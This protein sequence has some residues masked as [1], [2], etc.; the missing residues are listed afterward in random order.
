MLNA[1]MGV[2]VSTVEYLTGASVDSKPWAMTNIDNWSTLDMITIC[3]TAVARD[4]PGRGSLESCRS[5]A[6]VTKS[7]PTFPDE[8]SV[9]TDNATKFGH[10][11]P[12]E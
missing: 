5:M 10:V 12:T 9:S 7:V 2:V 4:V 11:C 8:W 1:T 3:E 6:N